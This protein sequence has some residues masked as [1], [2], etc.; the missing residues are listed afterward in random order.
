MRSRSLAESVWA[1]SEPV[2]GVSEYETLLLGP[3]QAPGSR[4]L[5]DLQV[6]VLMGAD[7]IKPGEEEI[8][9]SLKQF[10]P[11]RRS[12]ILVVPHPP[13]LPDW[14]KLMGHAQITSGHLG[15]GYLDPEK[16]RD[17]VQTPCY[18]YLVLGV[19]DGRDL[20][21]KSAKKS[22]EI[23]KKRNRSPLTI[24]EAYLLI[25]LF[26]PALLHHHIIAAGS[27]YNGDGVPVFGTNY[28]VAKLVHCFL[29]DD[30][31][32]RGVASCKDRIS[33]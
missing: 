1:N 29:H 11:K 24:W 31:P 26:T 5:F 2:V 25:L 21:G 18:P 14:N 30:D 13:M 12:L 8:L 3:Q 28:I 15:R 9:N 22:Q 4:K 16:I 32:R 17:V 20:L 23:L 33:I 19:N 27:I 10:L 6:S 7:L